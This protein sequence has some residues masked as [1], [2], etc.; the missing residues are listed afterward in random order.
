MS[1]STAEAADQGDEESSMETGS[2]HVPASEEYTIVD[3][4]RQLLHTAS[5]IMSDP[6]FKPRRPEE[7]REAVAMTASAEQKKLGKGLD[8]KTKD[9]VK[10]THEVVEAVLRGD[11]RPGAARSAIAGQIQTIAGLEVSPGDLVV[12]EV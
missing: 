5:T 3:Y 4:A 8:K 7:A 12:E 10:F 2:P 6:K 11:R 1:P 9:L